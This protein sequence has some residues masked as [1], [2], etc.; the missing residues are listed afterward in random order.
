MSSQK[1]KKKKNIEDSIKNEL[2][3]TA[4][5]TGILFALKAINVKPAKSSL[6]VMD[7]MKLGSGIYGGVFVKGY[8]VYKN[9]LTSNTKKLLWPLKGNKSTQC[10]MQ[11]EKHRDLGP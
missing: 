7:T 5:T 11:I 3:I 8:V 9:G 4:T 1:S 2:I 10:Q 6:D